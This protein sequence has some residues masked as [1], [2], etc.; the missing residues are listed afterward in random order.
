MKKHAIIGILLLS[1][2]FVPPTIAQAVVLN[3]A[4]PVGGRMTSIPTDL[5]ASIV[6]SATYGPFLLTPFN[7]SVPGPFFIQDSKRGT[8]K[9]NGYFLGLYKP[10]PDM[11]TCYNPETGAPIPAFGIKLY[12]VSR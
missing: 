4:A 10:M 7:I 3:R 12:G 1:L 9:R 2:M 11:G 6:C 5:Q 8:P